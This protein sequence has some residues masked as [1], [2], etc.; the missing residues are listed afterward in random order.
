MIAARFALCDPNDGKLYNVFMKLNS[1]LTLIGINKYICNDELSI[2]DIAFFTN[3]GELKSGVFDDIPIGFIEQFPAIEALYIKVGTHPKI[4]KRY[5][6][7]TEGLLFKA[8]K[9]TP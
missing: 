7:E 8:F 2:A 1:Y 6:N 9:V 3:I 5:V 4:A